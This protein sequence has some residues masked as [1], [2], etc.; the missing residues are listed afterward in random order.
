MRP[1]S[2]GVDADAVLTGREPSGELEGSQSIDKCIIS[3]L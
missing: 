3:A 2:P 1:T